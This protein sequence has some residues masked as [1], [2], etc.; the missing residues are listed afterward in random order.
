MKHF[1][2]PRLPLWVR[3]YLFAL[4]NDGRVLGKGE[5]RLSVDPYA[6]ASEFSRAITRAKQQGLLTE[7]SSARMLV[8]KQSTKENVPPASRTNHGH[9]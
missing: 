3:V 2:N 1:T 5:L 4:V 7:E 8:L 6:R 9:R